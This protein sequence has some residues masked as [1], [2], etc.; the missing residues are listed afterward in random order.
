MNFD[1]S[2]LPVRELSYEDTALHR[3][4]ETLTKGPDIL[5]FNEYTEK[6]FSTAR[7][8]PIDFEVKP[9]EAAYS[10]LETAIDAPLWPHEDRH[11]V[12]ADPIEG[13]MVAFLNRLTPR[14]VCICTM[15]SQ[16]EIAENPDTREFHTYRPKDYQYDRNGGFMVRPWAEAN[17]E[18]YIDTLLSHDLLAHCKFL[19]SDKLREMGFERYNGEFHN[20]FD[21]ERGDDD[22][23]ALKD[24]LEAEGLD[25][26]YICTG[27]NTFHISWNTYVR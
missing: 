19:G 21:P 25:V 3:Q 24:R 14:D 27:A 15:E 13:Q 4:A 17:P 11:Y 2:D 12:I 16:Y 1:Y 18:K 8:E 23:M 20:D 9:V 5:V 7:E 10:V 22:P 6:A 26:L